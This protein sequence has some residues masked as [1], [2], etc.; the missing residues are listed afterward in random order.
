M[1]SLR[2]ITPHSGVETNTFLGEE[3][4]IVKKP[5]LN[6][7][8]DPKKS[9]FDSLLNHSDGLNPEEKESVSQFIILDPDRVIPILD[10]DVNYIVTD[11]GNT[12]AKI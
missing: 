6:D 12:Y 4:K 10:T 2:R 1:Y 8:R 3:Y 11:R 5:N 7:S 9:H